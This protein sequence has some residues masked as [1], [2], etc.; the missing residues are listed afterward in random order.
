MNLTFI[1]INFI[2]FEIISFVLTAI[3]LVGLFYISLV[4]PRLK[5]L[6]KENQKLLTI[7]Y[8]VT[9][10]PGVLA[11]IDID[12]RPEEPE[13]GTYKKGVIAYNQNNF[14]KDLDESQIVAKINSI[15]H[16]NIHIF[17]NNVTAQQYLTNIRN[18]I[19]DS[20]S[21]YSPAIICVVVFFCLFMKV[22]LIRTSVQQI[23]GIKSNKKKMNKADNI[24]EQLSIHTNM[25]LLPSLSDNE[26]NSACI[27]DNDELMRD[28]NSQSAGKRLHRE[29][30][31]FLSKD[32]PIYNPILSLLN[33]KNLFNLFFF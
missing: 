25:P 28:S 22:T 33:P 24:L 30:Q 10:N 16:D 19:N 5:G 32:K 17:S 31:K 18:I 3:S 1:K 7:Y 11:D 20:N 26:T 8:N 4:F 15:N 12:I 23:R 9:Y 2:L 21:I 29:T 14:D 27:K 6:Q 13:G